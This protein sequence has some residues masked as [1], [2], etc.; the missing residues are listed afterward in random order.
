MYGLYLYVLLF[1][2]DDSLGYE[3]LFIFKVVKKDGFFCVWCLWY[4]YIFLVVVLGEK[5]IECFCLKF[6]WNKMYDL[7]FRFCRGCKVE[8]NVEDFNF[9]GLFFVIDWEFIVLY[10]RY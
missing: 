8:C 7:F 2:S 4:R 9:G 1:Y 10:L 5:N 6:L 3:Y